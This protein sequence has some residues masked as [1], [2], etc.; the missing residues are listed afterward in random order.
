LARI[1]RV[2][3]FEAAGQGL[4]P[5]LPAR[6]YALSH[7]GRYKWTAQLER[8]D[9]EDGYFVRLLHVHGT[10][11]NLDSAVPA[12]LY[13]LVGRTLPSLTKAL[14]AINN[15]GG[16]TRLLKSGCATWRLQSTH[17]PLEQEPFARAARGRERTVQV[18]SQHRLYLFVLVLV[19]MLV[20]L[21]VFGTL[22]L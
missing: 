9:N 13:R 17:Q 1:T 10:G 4:Q 19:A 8:A 14:G 20:V 12:H 21:L 5:Q 18:G 6:I 22:V 15:R 3:M 7:H 16:D 11:I 2:M